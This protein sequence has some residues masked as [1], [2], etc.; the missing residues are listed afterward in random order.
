MNGQI[1][2]EGDTYI[3]LEIMKLKD[4]FNLKNCIETGTQY[5]ATTNVLAEI[6]NNV[7]TIEGDASHFV[8]AKERVKKKNVVFIH[9]LS[10][11]ALKD[12]NFDDVLY[13]LDAHG[14][15][16]GG[17]PLKKELEIIAGKSHKNKAIAIHDFKVPGK[18]FGFDSYDY[19]LCFEE[20]E[21]YLINIFPKGFKYHY[22]EEADGAKRG[23]IYIYE[24]TDFGLK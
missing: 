14:C 11:K 17:C 19:D 5:G 16:I 12:V 18:D 7:T 22:N 10:E 3:G 15:E 4:K 2:F 24:N 8:I 20:I 21:S 9:G 1:A 6:F 23:I 13:Y